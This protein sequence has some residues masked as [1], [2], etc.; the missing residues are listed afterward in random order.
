[1]VATTNYDLLYEAADPPPGRKV[2]T[3]R[4]ST[5]ALGYIQ[6]KRKVLFKVHG[7]AES[8]STVVMTRREY[9]E[10][11]KEG[12]YQRIMSH[13]LQSY[14]FLLV[15]YGMNDPF[16]LD[17]LFKLN[18]KAFGEAGRPHYVLMRKKEADPH[19]DR[20]QKEMNVHVVEYDD[21]GALPTML[22]TLA[23]VKPNPR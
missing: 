11:A 12:P 15:G 9:D 23:G 20:W 14:T 19:R 3:W 16:D 10:A 6:A 7:S 18:S 21:H 5:D 22:R 17:L 4:E 13:L 1:V 2:Y 8:E